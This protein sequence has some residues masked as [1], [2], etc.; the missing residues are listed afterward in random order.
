MT[1]SST[2]LIWWHFSDLHWE[3]GQSG[4]RKRFLSILL[5]NLKKNIE[6][7]GEPDFIVMSGDIS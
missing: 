3:T 1:K 6:E 4:E 5:E 7:I 2:E